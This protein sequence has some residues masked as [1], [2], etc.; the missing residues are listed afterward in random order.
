VLVLCYHGVSTTWPDPLAIDPDRLRWQV[1]RL[2]YRGWTPATFTDALLAPPARRTRAVTFDDGLRSVLELALPVLDELGAVGT[3]FV[4]TAMVDGARP[5]S[6]P[7]VDRWIGSEHEH[8]LRG[9]SW[10]ELAELASAG[11]EV[12]SHSA[13]HA[14]LTRLADGPLRAELRDSKAEIEAR[15]GRHCRSIAY[16]Y[17]DVDDRVAAATRAA[18]YEAGAAVLPARPRRD[19]MRF[20][21]VP[22]LSGE[23]RLGHRLHVSRPMRRLQAI[24]GWPAVQRAARARGGEP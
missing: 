13:T 8:E 20:P 21:R 2:L 9:M 23:S 15:L 7:G 22:V 16:P 3:A 24:R 12:G 18:G 14:H 11:W 4:P 1:A 6:W 5:F 10:A 19:P 17:S